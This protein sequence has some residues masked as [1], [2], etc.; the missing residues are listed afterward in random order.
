MKITKVLFLY[1]CL[2]G[3]VVCSC[4]TLDLREANHELVN[5]YRAK[6]EAINS[7]N[8]EQEVTINGALSILAE[9]A[10]EKCEDQTMPRINRIP[11]CRIAA[12]A[13]WQA[14][15]E[16]VVTY[17]NNG[18]S[19]CHEENYSKA[20]RDCGMLLIIPDLASVDELI[21]RYNELNGRITHESNPPTKEEVVKLY[22]DIKSRIHSLLTKRDTIKQSCTHPKLLE[23]LDRHM[24]TIFC[25]HFHE[26]LGLIVQYA[27]VGSDAHKDAQCH[28]YKLKV[29]LKKLGFSQQMAPCLPAGAPT[30]PSGCQ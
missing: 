11:F 1:I 2:S 26:T 15:H 3:M 27:G 5:L 13:A 21:R 24:G 12:T 8:A 20:P 17:A 28:E 14:G 19:L 22:A 30:K 29:R 23:S 9:Q 7:S 6:I 16:N 10:A 18:I 4:A 25:R